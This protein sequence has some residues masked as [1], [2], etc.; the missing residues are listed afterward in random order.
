MKK[1]SILLVVAIMIFTSV[2]SVS[3]ANVFSEDSHFSIDVG[4][5]YEYVKENSTD[6]LFY[7]V[8]AD[9]VTN[10]TVNYVENTDNECLKDLTQENYDSYAKVFKATMT[11][12]YAQQQI[13]ADIEVVSVDSKDLSSGYTALISVIKTKI[14][15]TVFYQKMYQFAGVDFVY[16]IALTADNMDTIDELD[17]IADT[18]KMNED[19]LM[20]SKDTIAPAGTIEDD[21]DIFVPMIIIAA[22]IIGGII[23]L[24][25]NKNQKKKREAQLGAPLQSTFDTQQAQEIQAEFRNQGTENRDL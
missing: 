5:E 15:D 12:Q 16:T 22:A 13:K 17:A 1:V 6:V 7:F 11:S 21:F 25:I 4:D 18:F 10:I 8:K 9:G 23:G 2:I 14:Q 24:V 20:P 19:E 3:A